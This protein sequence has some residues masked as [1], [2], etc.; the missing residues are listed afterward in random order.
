MKAAAPAP[1][2]SCDRQATPHESPPAP[3]RHF[4]FAARRWSWRRAM[5]AQTGKGN[6]KRANRKINTKQRVAMHRRGTNHKQS[7]L[8]ADS[9]S[10]LSQP[11]IHSR[12][13]HEG[14]KRPP[15]TAPAGALTSFSLLF[16]EQIQGQKNAKIARFYG[17]R[18]Y[19]TRSVK[20]WLVKRGRLRE[21]VDGLT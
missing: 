14:R 21:A 2:Q 6:S 10:A 18:Y 19:Q 15:E 7:R 11:Q 8:Q 4:A 16:R 3:P 20:R 5:R 9:H 12:S 1:I 17:L 13:A